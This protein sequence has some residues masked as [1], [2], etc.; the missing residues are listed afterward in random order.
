VTQSGDCVIGSSAFEIR[1]DGESIRLQID[2]GDVGVVVVVFFGEQ[3]TY[4]RQ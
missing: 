2:A 3:D 1:H 4:A